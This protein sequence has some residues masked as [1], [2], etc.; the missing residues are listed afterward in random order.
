MSEAL[1][2]HS[3]PGTSADLFHALPLDILDPF[4]YPS[5]TAARSR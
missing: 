3:A 4:L 1:L 2:I 5:A